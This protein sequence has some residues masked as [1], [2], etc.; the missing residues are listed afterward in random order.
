[1]TQI[2]VE[3]Y[4]TAIFVDSSV[5]LTTDHEVASILLNIMFHASIGRFQLEI[6]YYFIYFLPSSHPFGCVGS[7]RPFVN[8]LTSS[9][10]LVDC[11]GFFFRPVWAVVKKLMKGLQEPTQLIGW[12]DG[13][14]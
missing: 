4:S 6:I 10:G 8:L 12:D 5:S 11:R 2:T 1:M 13:E 3:L 9:A 7:C 14:A